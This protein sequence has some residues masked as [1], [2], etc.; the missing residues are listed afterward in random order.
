MRK[1]FKKWFPFLFKKEKFFSDNFIT[2]WKH[3][4][5][6]FLYILISTKLAPEDFTKTFPRAV[7]IEETE[8]QLLHD[9]PNG[10]E[11]V[12]VG[13]DHIINEH[14]ADREIDGPD[15]DIKSEIIN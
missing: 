8:F 12:T 7:Q 15:Q 13:D 10:P 9:D 5:G 1:Y 6:K 3:D 4:Q 2:F 11:L 14:F